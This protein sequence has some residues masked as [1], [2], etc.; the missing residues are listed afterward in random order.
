MWHLEKVVIGT[1]GG[2]PN[3][4]PCLRNTLRLD[5]WVREGLRRGFGDP[6]TGDIAPPPPGLVY[7]RTKK[8]HPRM[9]LG[10]W[11]ACD[12]HIRRSVPCRRVK[13]RV[14][15]CCCEDFR[16]GFGGHCPCPSLDDRELQLSEVGAE[17]RG[18]GSVVMGSGAFRT[19]LRLFF[20]LNCDVVTRW[21]IGEGGVPTSLPRPSTNGVSTPKLLRRAEMP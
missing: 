15:H 5:E 14:V 13:L 1:W 2:P 17:P 10:S 21:C 18:P 3:P 20:P 11:E 12:W 6:P 19:L 4:F 7:A 16:W 8:T 9:V